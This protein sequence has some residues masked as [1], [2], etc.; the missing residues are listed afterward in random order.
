MCRTSAQRNQLVSWFMNSRPCAG[1]AY[2]PTEGEHIANM[3][4]HGMWI[5][6]SIAGLIWMLHLSSGYVQHVVAILY[7][8]CM[9]AL[10]TISTTFHALAYF[11]DPCSKLRNFFHLGDRAVI[12]L[13]IAA[14][15][16]PWLTLKEYS[17]YSAWASIMLSLVW[18]AA[19]LGIIYQYTFHERYKWLEIVFYLSLGVAP[20]IVVLEMKDST[21]VHEMAVG[22]I[23]Y[24]S[25]VIFFKCD[26]IIP[27]AH[28]IWHCF[29]FLGALFHFRAV[30]LYLLGSQ[31][32]GAYRQFNLEWYS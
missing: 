20:S 5:L 19:F 14:S 31:S 13:F 28:A 11:S 30:C 3:V 15:Y 22:G 12:Y 24:I 32:D 21:G 29:V 8:L 7:G 23:I 9:F 25:G 18:L 4:T 6:P 17:Q 10:F 16:T 2:V 27:F 1:C 26:G